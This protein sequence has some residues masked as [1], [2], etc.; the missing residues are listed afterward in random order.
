MTREIIIGVIGGYGQIGLEVVKSLL[1]TTNSTII[2]AGRKKGRGIVDCNNNSRVS[3]EMLDIND[4]QKLSLFC[5]KCEIIMNCAGPAT[6]VS[7]KISFSA[8]KQKKHYIDLGGC[9][10]LY[11]DLIQKNSIIK[12]QCLTFVLS[13]GMFPGIFEIF[14]IYIARKHFSNINSLEYYFACLDRITF[15]AAYDM[16]VEIFERPNAGLDKTDQPQTVFRG[17]NEITLPDPVGKITGHSFY[18]E[19]THQIVKALNSKTAL[20]YSTFCGEM[21]RKSLFEI[22]MIKKYD[23]SNIVDLSN[24]LV[25]ASEIDVKKNKSYAMFYLILSGE[26]EGRLKKVISTLSVNQSHRL[27]G[28]VAATVAKLI[29]SGKLEKHGCFALHESN[30]INEFIELLMQQGIIL[31][32]RQIL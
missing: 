19:E 25:Q 9:S 1:K 8:L 30:N 7:K 23:E 27:S 26:S 6:K 2:I 17:S 12:S 3:Y 11:R 18:N 28:I 32:E 24:Q 10:S 4:P 21:T 14:P 31:D 29:I 20:F 5:N 22:S 13:A 15:S 16:V